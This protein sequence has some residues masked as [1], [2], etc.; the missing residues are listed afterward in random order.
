[1]LIYD[2]YFIEKAE[3]KKRIELDL[4]NR[5]ASQYSVS[6]TIGDNLNAILESINA[7]NDD[8]R[9]AETL[10]A[11][12]EICIRI[13]EKHPLKT[14]SGQERC[15]YSGVSKLLWFRYPDTGWTMYDGLAKE[16]LNNLSGDAL[17]TK[18]TGPRSYYGILE[19]NYNFESVCEKTQKVIDESKFKGKLYAERIIDK[20][21]ML[22]GMDKLPNAELKSFLRC[23]PNC[24]RK[25]LFKTA[26]K[27]SNIIEENFKFQNSIK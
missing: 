24:M 20:Y 14:E 10:T 18:I 21:L 16:G 25:C 15:P 4:G 23:Y 27:T 7:K 19:K 26:K 6:R 2:F 5:I 13:A 17:K 3:S 12:A 1:M 11:K 8:W 9:K 22:H